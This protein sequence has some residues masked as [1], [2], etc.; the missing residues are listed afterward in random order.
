MID[1]NNAMRIHVAYSSGKFYKHTDT[2]VILCVVFISLCIKH[3]Y[4]VS[5]IDGSTTGDAYVYVW[6]YMRGMSC[7]YECAYFM[8]VLAQGGASVD[9]T[10]VMHGQSYENT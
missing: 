5:L 3:D 2:S 8:S 7:V 1:S 10:H 6:V 4:V 9:Q